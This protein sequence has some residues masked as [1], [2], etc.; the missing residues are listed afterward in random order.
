[1]TNFQRE[2]S[3][4]ARQGAIALHEWLIAMLQAGF[5]EDQAVRII[6]ATLGFTNFDQGEE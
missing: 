1:M 5:T 4:N 3:A 2:P 6:G